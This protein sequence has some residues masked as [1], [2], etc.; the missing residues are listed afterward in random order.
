MKE[1]IGKKVVM[2][3]NFIVISACH[4]FLDSKLVPK[5]QNSRLHPYK[6]VK[7]REHHDNPFSHDT[8]LPDRQS[9][10]MGDPT[11]MNYC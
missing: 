9:P 8:V 4:V 11:C 6:R 3:K 1:S 5:D 2:R 10:K 7:G